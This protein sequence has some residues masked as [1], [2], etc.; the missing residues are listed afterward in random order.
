VSHVQK[1]AALIV[2]DQTP[3]TL[4]ATS[5]FALSLVLW[6]AVV[7][8]AADP[9]PATAGGPVSEAPP[10]TTVTV[11]EDGAESTFATQS[12]TVGDVLAERGIHASA[13][14]YVSLDP[15]TPIVDGARIVVRTA[16]PIR[17]RVGAELRTV[18]SADAT[19]GDL[20]RDEHVA[21]GTGDDVLPSRTSELVANETIDVVRVRT[22]YVRERARISPS[23]EQRTDAHMLAG[24]KETLADGVP[25]MRETIV[26]FTQRNEERPQSAVVASR[27]VR[28]PR[29]KI[30]VRGLATYVSLAHA[31][32]QS[33]ERAVHL[34]G[35]AI[36]MI[37]TAYTAGCYG[38]SGITASGLRAGF[39]IIA[40]DPSVIPL[41]TKV[42][43]PGYGRAIAGDTGGAIVG[44]RV[45]L[46]M[47]HLA[48][49][50][51]FGRRAMTVYVLK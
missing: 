18:R 45:D 12:R 44:N 38:C 24:Q 4:V 29:A 39:G 19:V 2:K 3:A 34:A 1:G 47:N 10:V 42:F 51:R 25:G 6:P 41:G 33:F 21:L 20:L 28:A 35:S 22:W 8:L 11:V 49:A 32:S 48:D 31:A 23:V 40:V 9:A 50:L 27:I 16:I 14:D 5:F 13:G 30:V 15:S 43:I 46:G 37:A 17:L 7:A 26:R 36:H